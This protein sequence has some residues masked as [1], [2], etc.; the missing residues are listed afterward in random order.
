MKEKTAPKGQAKITE[1]VVSQNTSKLQFSWG[2][3]CTGQH[4][5]DATG[6][7]V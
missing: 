5:W 3:A 7:I 4:S 6:S 2:A 1:S